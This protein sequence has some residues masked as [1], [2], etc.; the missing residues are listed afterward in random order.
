[1]MKA[2]SSIVTTY[3][4]DQL[5]ESPSITFPAHIRVTEKRA[6][7]DHQQLLAGFHELYY[8][9]VH[10]TTLEILAV[11]KRGP[12]R[13][14]RQWWG[15]PL[16]YTL[17]GRRNLFR[18]AF[19]IAM[20]K[21]VDE[22]LVGK[23][24]AAAG[25]IAWTCALI[26]DD[27]IDESSEREGHPCAH[28]QYGRVRSWAAVVFGLRSVFRAL[29]VLPSIPITR[30]LRMAWLSVCLLARCLRTQVPKL[31]GQLS[32]LKA[33]DKDARDVNSSTH[34]ALLAPLM[35]CAD[36]DTVV[37]VW[38]Y[39]NA[40]SVNG[41]MRNDLLD[42]CGGSTENLTQYEDFENHRLTFPSIVLLEQTPTQE[43]LRVLRRHFIDQQVA[44]NFG[45]TDLIHLFRKYRTYE[46]CLEL[47]REKAKAGREAIERIKSRPNIPDE[48]PELLMSWIHHQIDLAEE[49]VQATRSMG[50]DTI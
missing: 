46:C 15:E 9:C 2:A 36:E 30:R 16:L 1:M 5:K 19:S 31:S 48:V 41:K 12:L 6:H 32:N 21:V 22:E 17:E 42:Y 26:A 24:A 47:M 33:F 28:I 23:V 20:S 49:R 50:G 8:Q 39:A 35:I 11:N 27:M 4:P 10:G 44:G 43:D 13:Q 37:A 3:D 14:W 29:L 34:W 25:E 40:I 7:I 45:I 18:T 38:D